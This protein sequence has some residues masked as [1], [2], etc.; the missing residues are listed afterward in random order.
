MEVKKMNQHDKPG[1]SPE[2]RWLIAWA[3]LFAVLFAGIAFATGQ[4]W[5]IVVIAWLLGSFVGVGVGGYCNAKE[6]DPTRHH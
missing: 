5:S 2:L 4:H 1:T 3:A 6:G